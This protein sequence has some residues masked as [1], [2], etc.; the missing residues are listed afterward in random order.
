MFKFKSIFFLLIFELLSFTAMAQKTHVFNVYF[1]L[2][3]Y[4]LSAVDQDYIKS[5]IDNFSKVNV[6]KI[7]IIG[8]TDNSADSLYNIKLS[9]RRANEVKNALVSLGFN[10]HIIE[11]GYFGE[12]KPIVKND[13]EK[14]R[15]LNRRA[16]IILH[17][18]DL[19]K[20]CSLGDTI[21]RTKGGKEIV[22]DGCEFKEIENCIE[23]L[24]QPSQNDFKKGIV[25]MGK[26]THNLVN[27]G[28]LQINLLDGCVK[29]ECFKNPVRIRFPV[30]SPPDTAN[31][32]WVLVKG[33][34][35]VLRIIELKSK[36]FY[37]FELKCPTSWINCNCKKNQKH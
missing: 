14:E 11:I 19:E 3:K 31:L 24:E 10:E 35:T 20:K 36:L 22:F 6:N 37:E 1:N 7:E 30:S 33:E 23:I 8:H 34:K 12:N 2:N 27:Y 5:E 21:I 25:V 9:N 28:R 4:V 17:Y 13:N 26:N 32:P 29:N 16:E 18:A 15:K